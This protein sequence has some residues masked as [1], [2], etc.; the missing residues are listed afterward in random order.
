MSRLI[1][2]RRALG[3]AALDTGLGAAVALGL[4]PWGLWPLAVLAL[5]GIVRRVSET[6]PIRCA[7]FAGAGYFAL[8][9]SWITEPFFVQPEVHGWMAP[10]ALMGMALGGGVFWAL[11]G[12]LARF[13]PPGARRA[14]GFAAGLVLSDWLRGWVFTGFPWALLGHIWIETPVAQAAAWGGALA[15][16][17]LSATAAMLPVVLRRRAGGA[18]ASVALIGVIWGLGAWRL[19]QPEPD[20]TAS[21]IRLVQPNAMQSLKWDPVWAGE[22]YRR[23][24]DLSAAEGAADLVIWPETAVSFLLND[25]DPALPQ[26]AAAAGVP[27]LMGIQRA[28][29]RRY[30]NSLVEITPDARIGAIYDK[31]HLVPFGEYIPWGNELTR[32]GVRAF[33]AQEGF[34]Y[35]P[36][37]GK[38]AMQ[39]GGAPP[40]QP[41]ICYEV[42]FPQHILRGDQRPRWLLQATNDAWFGAVSGPWQHL[43]QARLRAIESG[44]PVVRA[45]N[46]GISAV[47][48]GKGRLRAS[49]GLNVEGKIDAALPA[50]LPETIYQRAGDWPV[51]ALAMLALAGALIRRRSVTG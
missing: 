31:F 25:A 45:A 49:L 9:L 35:S 17:V 8:A 2:S 43:A 1:P 12:A 21:R 51:L 4:A 30:Y 5:A 7:F 13:A 38:R 28:E 14:L 10:F 18:L 19:A 6:T 36:G 44:L 39:I 47:I 33:A 46:T 27:V 48:D 42:I 50:A 3:A 16:S 32:F 34:G 37:P 29:G 20:D 24:L 26:I 11:A 40:F 22:F 41:L 23:L 15:L